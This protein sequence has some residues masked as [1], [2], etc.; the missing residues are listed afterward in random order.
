MVSLKFCPNCGNEITDDDVEFCTECG[1][2]LVNPTNESNVKSKGFFND[3]AEKTSF[4]IIVF[5]FI[6]FG[7]FLFVGSIFWSSFMSSGSIDL[8]TYLLLVVTFSVFFGGIFIGYKG[9]EDKTFVIPNFSMY[10]GS[11]F[12]VVLCILGFIFTFFMGIFS[13]LSSLFSGSS[14]TAYSSHSY[15]SSLQTQTPSYAPSIDLSGVLKILLF[16]LLIPVA[17]YLGVYLGFILKENI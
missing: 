17:A 12:A 15:S 4:P 3:M 11:I 16:I 6:I 9:C 5:S 13:A 7:V 14:S 1:C 2:N 10:L 8:I